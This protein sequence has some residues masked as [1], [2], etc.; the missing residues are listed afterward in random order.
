[1]LARQEKFLFTGNKNETGFWARGSGNKKQDVDMSISD[2]SLD[3]T[4]VN[5]ATHNVDQQNMTS[6]SVFSCV[7][8]DRGFLPPDIPDM[9]CKPNLALPKVF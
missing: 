2:V 7:S 5:V 8:S 4:N 9:H 3:M 1:M 6:D